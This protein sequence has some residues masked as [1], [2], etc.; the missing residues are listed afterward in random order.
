MMSGIIPSNP[1]RSIQADTGPLHPRGRRCYRRVLAELVDT[2]GLARRSSGDHVDT[3]HHVGLAMMSG[4]VLERGLAAR[5]EW[6][7]CASLC[8]HVVASPARAA[9]DVQ[10]VCSQCCLLHM[11]ALKS[12]TP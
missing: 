4:M 1:G 8:A 6:D 3:T 11:C 9:V 10:R 12:G 2:D 5:P 7:E